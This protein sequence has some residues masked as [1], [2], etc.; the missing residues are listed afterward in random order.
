M[1]DSTDLAEVRTRL[2]AAGLPAD[3]TELADL[4][5]ALPGQRAAVAALYAVPAAR[6]VDPA[7]RFRADAA[8]VDWSS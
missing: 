2:A 3:D 5:A 1:P 6:Y 7:L 4:A 8:I